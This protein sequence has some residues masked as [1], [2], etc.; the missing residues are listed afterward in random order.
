MTRDTSK[1]ALRSPD[2]PPQALQLH[3][4][5]HRPHQNICPRSQMD[6]LNDREGISYDDVVIGGGSAGLSAIIL[7]KQLAKRGKYGP[8]ERQGQTAARNMLERRETCNAVPFF[9]AQQYVV[10]IDYLGHAAFWDRIEQAGHLASRDVALRL[11]KGGCALAV[12]TI[13]RGSES[14]KAELAMEQGR[15]P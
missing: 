5:P 6:R 9:R 14:L 8:S 3:D 13:F 15:T 11:Y 12:V 10:A 1:R 4:P 2:T 7:L